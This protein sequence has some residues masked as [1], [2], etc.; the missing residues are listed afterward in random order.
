MTLEVNCLPC[1][2]R[3]APREKRRLR[4]TP[5]HEGNVRETVPKEPG[6]YAQILY[7][8]AP[9]LLTVGALGR[10]RL[11]PGFYVYVGS[12]LGPGGLRARLARHI[13]RPARLHWHVDYLRTHARPVEIWLRTGAESEEHLWAD[14]LADLADSAIPRFGASDCRCRSHLFHFTRRPDPVRFA[15]R[16][17]GEAAVRRVNRLQIE[18]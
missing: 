11:S 17:G 8:P 2:S 6:T 4:A 13:G 7:L 10:V 1:R 5:A 9:V 15:A 14:I 12:A 3:R 16:L 18:N